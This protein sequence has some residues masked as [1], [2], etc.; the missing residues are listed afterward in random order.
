[1]HFPTIIAASCATLAAATAPASY[2]N[3]NN[4]NNNNNKDQ[5]QL[6]GNFA[7]SNFVFG[8]TAGCNYSFDLA[9]EGSAEN[10]PAVTKSV[11]CSGDL[12]ATD[13]V[14]CGHVSKTQ[15]LYAYIE[16]DTNK[17]KLEYEVSRPKASAVYRYTGE[18]TVYAATSDQADK[19]KKNFKVKETAATGVA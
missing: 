7:V 18:K 13:Y 3:N 10:H 8:C 17:L 4:N 6:P 12:E 5:N 16:K 2:N 11:K 9:V 14:Q 1:M 19:Q 15:R